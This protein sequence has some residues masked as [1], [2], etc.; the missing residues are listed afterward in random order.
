MN[1]LQQ[2]S[3]RPVIKPITLAPV[4][5]REGRVGAFKAKVAVVTT[6]DSNSPKW[7]S[8]KPMKKQENNE[9]SETQKDHPESYHSEW[10]SHVQI[11]NLLS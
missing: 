11:F 7:S 9:L 3:G 2:S 10:S 1:A 8:A 5:M 4:N 6:K